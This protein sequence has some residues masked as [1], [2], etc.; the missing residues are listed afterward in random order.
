VNFIT[1]F[2]SLFKDI[3]LLSF[4]IIVSFILMLSS[5]SKIVEGLR[6]STLLS[7][8]FIQENIKA[9]GSY[10][11]LK[12]INKELRRENTRLAYDNFQLQDVLLENIRLHRLLQF[13]YKAGFEPVPAKIIGFSPQ[14]FVTGFLLSTENLQKVQKNDAVI[15]VDGLVG[16]IVKLSANY[17]ICQDLFDP[18]SRISVRV[19]RNR[20]LGIISWDGGSGLLLKQITNTVEIKEG[21]VLFTSGMSRI[22]P[23]NIKVGHVIRVEKQKEQLFQ[24]IQVKPAVN[25]NQIEEVFI[26][27]M[28]REN[29]SEY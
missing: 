14:D 17:G 6:S 13:K 16:K 26:V 7:F 3:L 24:T 5:D 29:G 4:Y 19:Q 8:G 25:F 18:N 20:E 28:K 23:S 9:A 27:H 12:S 11:D 21:D 2:I 22:F 15:T 1:H 10:F